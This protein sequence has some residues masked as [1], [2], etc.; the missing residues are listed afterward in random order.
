MRR[1]LLWVVAAIVLIATPAVIGIVALRDDGARSRAALV[2]EGSTAAAYQLTAA[3]ITPADEAIVVNS[4][5]WGVNNPGGLPSAGAGAGKANFE[6]LQFTKKIDQT[7]PKFALAAAQGTSIDTVVL[8]LYKPG[9]DSPKPY[10]VYTLTQAYVTSVQHTGAADELPNESISLAYAQVN[11]EI[12]GADV[13]G[14]LTKASQLN[15]DVLQ[16]T[17]SGS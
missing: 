13:K 11:V 7:S 3:G 17:G 8:R 4:Y 5:S 15:W 14:A 2:A 9:G 6:N 12:S 1:K 16:N 10:A